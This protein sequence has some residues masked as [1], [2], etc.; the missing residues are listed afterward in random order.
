MDGDCEFTGKA[1]KREPTFSKEKAQRASVYVREP[2]E[3]SAEKTPFSPLD[4]TFIKE[5]FR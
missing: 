2:V 1:E 4:L 3:L 5:S